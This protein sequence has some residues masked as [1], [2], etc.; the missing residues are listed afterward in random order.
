MTPFTVIVNASVGEVSSSPTTAVPPLSV[1]KT[2][3]V[4]VPKVF[5]ALVYVSVPS[6]AIDGPSENARSPVVPVGV[7]VNV[8][9]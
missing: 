3:Y 5:G 4:A 2:S 8:S 6:D 1:T 9:V 7:S